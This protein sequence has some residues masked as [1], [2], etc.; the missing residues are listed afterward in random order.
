MRFLSVNLDSFLIELNT[1]KKLLHCI[2][3]YN[4]LDILIFV[5]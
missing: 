1:S 5:K 3:S 2:G 4:S